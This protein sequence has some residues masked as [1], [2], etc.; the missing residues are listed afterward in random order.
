MT[1]GLW[2]IDRNELSVVIDA[3]L[4]E[5]A[6]ER[7]LRDVA[8]YVVSAGTFLDPGEVVEVAGERWEA[9]RGWQ[10]SLLLRRAPAEDSA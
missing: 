3:S 1:L 6:G 8:G 2:S 7:L 5:E 10:G 9:M 4:S